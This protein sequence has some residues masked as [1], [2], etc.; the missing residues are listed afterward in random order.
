VKS[1]L[2]KVINSLQESVFDKANEDDI[3]ENE[4]I[5]GGNLKH[6]EYIIIKYQKSLFILHLQETLLVISKTL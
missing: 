6:G 2:F 5:L 3:V 1:N 4:F